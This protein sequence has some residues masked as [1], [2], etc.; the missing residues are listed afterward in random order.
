MVSIV[1]MPLP[2][3]CVGADILV[4]NYGATNM[5]AFSQRPTP[6]LV[7]EVAPFPNA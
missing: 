7:K 5:G 3:R 6:P 2:G 1:H 4:L